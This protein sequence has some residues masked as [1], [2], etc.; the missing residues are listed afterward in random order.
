MLAHRTT[1]VGGQV[2]ERRLIGGGCHDDH[3]VL[4]GAGLF[5]PGDGLG[6]GG[7]LLA[8]RH[9]D[10]V[11]AEAG[12]VEDRVD[13]NRGLAGLAVADDQLALATADRDQRVNRLDAG[14][15]GLPHRLAAG[16][17]RRLNLHAAL[18]DV[19]QRALAV[20]RVAQGVH[21]AAE[22]AVADRHRQD[23]TRSPNGVALGDLVGPAEDHRT[24]R[25]LI[26]VERQ[27]PHAALELE[28][29]VDRAVGQT[30]D[31]GDAIAHLGHPA[32]LALGE[33]GR[34]AFEVAANGVGDLGWIK[35]LGHF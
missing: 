13:R 35:E 1:G 10:A 7:G 6:D 16:D 11:H 32:D 21:H 18:H 23:L 20:D 14:L 3:R 33:V 2:L 12:L 8:D 30:G 4:H 9:V 29:R 31:A 24:D 25:I 27:A 22:H 34:E 17:A 5:E 15:E 19:G 28:Q 26:Q